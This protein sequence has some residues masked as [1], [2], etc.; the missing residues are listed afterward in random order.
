LIARLDVAKVAWLGTSM[1]GLIGIGLAGQ[2]NS[3]V[4]RLVLNDIGPRLD[5]AAVERIGNYVG[6]PMRF[7]DLEQAIVYNRSI[8]AGFGLRDDEEWREA[9][10]SVL[11]REGDGYV[12]HYDP[13]IGVP[14]R[15]LSPEAVAASEQILWHL[16]D[17]ITCPALLVRG[18]QSDLLSLDAAAEMSARGPRPR[19]FS[20]PGVGHAP[21]FFDPLQIEAV[22][23]FL[24]EA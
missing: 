14:F 5:P 10:V 24:S 23:S 15:A 22:R 9:T 3:P 19:L 8:A 16:Y 13:A 18:M 12:F 6:L 17:A 7:A 21:M 4:E 1:G 11:K 2:P 20:V